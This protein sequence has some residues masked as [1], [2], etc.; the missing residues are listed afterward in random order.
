M[1]YGPEW[2]ALDASFEW[3]RRHAAPG[4]VV[5]TAAPHTAYVRTGVKAVLPP[6]EADPAEARRLLSSVPVRYVVLDSLDY[7]DL[8]QR[9]AGPA[10]HSAPERWRLVYTAPGR[11][12]K[13]SEVYERV[14]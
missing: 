5:A 8:S 3:V 2:Q 11:A 4:D 1:F 12:D 13:V 10:V 6:M 9:Y 14:N 7:L